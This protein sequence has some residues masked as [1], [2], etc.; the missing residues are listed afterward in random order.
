MEYYAREEPGRLVTKT[1][2]LNVAGVVPIDRAIERWRRRIR[3]RHG[4]A[5]LGRWDP[6]FPVDLR[7]IRKVD[8]QLGKSI[9]RHRRCSSRC[10]PGNSS[11]DT[12]RIGDRDSCPTGDGQSLVQARDVF[13]ERLRATA[14]PLALGL[15]V[16]D[17]RAQGLEAS[18]G[19]TDFGS[20]SSTSA[21][22]SSSRRCCSWRCS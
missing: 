5:D 12:I 11:G 20:T 4:F 9:E 17:V 21:S 19:A 16:I 3:A 7:R 6:P 22:S 13:V 14:D 10:R 1:T 8:E 18:R 15:A 2:T